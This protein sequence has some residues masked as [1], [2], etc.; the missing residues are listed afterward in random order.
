MVLGIWA[1]ATVAFFYF[2]TPYAW[3]PILVLA[4]AGVGTFLQL[5]ANL[6]GWKAEHLKHQVEEH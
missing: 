5:S 6:I 1:G 4:I 3:W 2:L